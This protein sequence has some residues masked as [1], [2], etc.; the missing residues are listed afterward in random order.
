MD[1]TNLDATMVMSIHHG[2]TPMHQLFE[3]IFRVLLH[4]FLVFGLNKPLSHRISL[5]AQ[6]ESHW[7]R[8]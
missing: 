6:I 4:C 5:L 8:C 3:L 1:L 7:E 2:H